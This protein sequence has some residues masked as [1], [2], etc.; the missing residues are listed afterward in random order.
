MVITKQE[1]LL[2]LREKLSGLP[3][4]DIDERVAFYGEM[5]DDRVEEG[6]TE[7]ELFFP[8]HPANN[9]LVI[10]KTNTLFP[11]FIFIFLLIIYSSKA[12]I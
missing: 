5:I 11:F 1:F 12:L 10:N 4:A 6:L 9:K 2:Q 8:P 3:Q 7:E